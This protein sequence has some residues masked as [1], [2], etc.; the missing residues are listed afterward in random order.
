MRL[1]RAGKRNDVFGVKPRFS[2][3]YS[4]VIIFIDFGKTDNLSLL[5]C[6]GLIMTVRKNF[7]FFMGSRELISQWRISSFCSGEYLK[8]LRSMIWL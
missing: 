7:S 1:D 5:N 3:Y 2:A 6:P 4:L 8:G